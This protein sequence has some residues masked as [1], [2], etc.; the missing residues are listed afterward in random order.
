[1]VVVA[2]WRSRSTIAGRSAGSRRQLIRPVMPSMGSRRRPPAPAPHPAGRPRK[3]MGVEPQRLR[4][5]VRSRALDQADDPPCLRSRSGSPMSGAPIEHSPSSSR[6][7][8]APARPD[9]G[10]DPSL[11]ELRPSYLP[12]P[13]NQRARE[14]WRVRGMWNPPLL[15]PSGP[16]STS[17]EGPTNRCG[18]GVSALSFH[19]KAR[20]EFA[21]R[22]ARKS[23]GLRRP[24]SRRRPSRREVQSAATAAAASQRP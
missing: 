5:L 10:P 12:C 1:M 15:A 6:R 4:E 17:R 22:R 7:S 20:F 18:A 11:P 16:G 9:R 2:R 13:D 21:L 8:S 24:G 3:V 14:R 23:F 19:D